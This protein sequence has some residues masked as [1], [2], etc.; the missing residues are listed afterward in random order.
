[1]IGEID[2]QGVLVTPLLAWMFIAYALSIPIRKVLSWI[3]F[4]R[5]VWHRA[6]FDVSLFF[7]LTGG[8]SVLANDWIGR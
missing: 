4:Y 1:M 3:G 5:L 7:V 2:L 8:V 6:L